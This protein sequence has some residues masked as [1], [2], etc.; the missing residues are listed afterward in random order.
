MEKL[1]VLKG[2]CRIHCNSGEYC[3][4]KTNSHLLAVGFVCCCGYK[5]VEFDGT[6]VRLVKDDE[7]VEVK[8]TRRKAGEV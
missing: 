6:V 3:Q 2:P 5:V 4:V 1:T 7:S 8:R